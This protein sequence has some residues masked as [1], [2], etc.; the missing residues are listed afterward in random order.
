MNRNISLHALAIGLLCLL[1]NLQALA[2]GLDARLDRNRISEG[3]TVTLILR[4]EGGGKAD[5]SPLKK[6]FDLL[7][8]GQST[9]MQM[10]NGRSS[11]WHEWQLLLA[12]K[13]SG[14]LQVPAVKLGNLSSQPLTLEVVPA[15]QAA[16]SGTPRP[17]MVE[18]EVSDSKPYVQ[19]KV[20]YTVRVLT[21]VK[22]QQPSL[23]DPEV[24]DAL[25]ERLGE[26]RQ[27][28]T[29]RN[30][31]S[32]H[33]V[34]RRYAIFPQ[35]S[36]ELQIAAP[37]LTAQVREPAD[38][39]RPRRRSL[40]G[41]RDPF[42]DFDQI[43]DS[44]FARTRPL[45]LRG[46]ALSLEVQ[47][48]P[49]GTPTPWLP[50]ESLTLDETWS[51]DPP[52]FRVGEPVTRIIAITAQGV[53]AAQLPDLDS[54]GIP[55]IN[56]YPDRPETQTRAE[57]DTLVVQ[58]VQRTA[59]VPSRAGSFALPPLELHWWDTRNNRAQVARL[60]GRTIEVQPGAPGA[61][62]APVAPAPAEEV[63]PA[64]VQGSGPAGGQAGAPASAPGLAGKTGFSTSPQEAGY[65]PWVSALLA[66]AWLISS[67]LWWRARRKRGVIPP[68][69]Q[70]GSV[71]QGHPHPAGLL[72]SVQQACESGD[73]KAARQALL[74]WAAARWPQDPPLRLEDIAR[75]LPGPGVSVFEELDRHLYAAGETNWDG[76]SAWQQLQP[77]LQVAGAHDPNS[78]KEALPP[79]YTR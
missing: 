13:R 20:I 10:I 36:G 31:Q 71:P 73:A 48:Q 40:F 44:A 76:G 62:P 65:W 72:R 30:G 38:N 25:V 51:P 55:G 57:G 2:A 21:R 9:R 43:F 50:A 52:Q 8:Q 6:D 75:R 79:L 78:K 18:A 77:L 11:S 66:L 46:Q 26:D 42:A 53:T 5:F 23:G 24:G 67:V 45:H 68:A 15:A 19:G 39:S 61:A 4:D 49:A 29:T 12:P 33:V 54:A 16:Q 37:L 63:A 74:D 69:R 41:G 14:K 59:L 1:L 47:P 56:A 35:H 70:A 27:Y 60:P 22:L 64:S 3:D 32:Y 17:V 28:Q 7:S 34:E 58:K